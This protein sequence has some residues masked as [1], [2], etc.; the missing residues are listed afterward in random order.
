MNEKVL[1]H[2]NTN[3]IKIVGL[4]EPIIGYSKQIVSS[5]NT[6]ELKTE[7]EKTLCREILHNMEELTISME[8]GIL[9]LAKIN[10]ILECDLLKD[11]NHSIK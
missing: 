9:K 1:N 11:D 2:I 7:D 6:N 4:I 3:L 5:V 8:T 10:E